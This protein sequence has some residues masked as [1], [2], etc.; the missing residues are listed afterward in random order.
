[1]GN[2]KRFKCSY[3]EVTV[4]GDVLQILVDTNTG[5][6]YLAHCFKNGDIISSSLTVLI[7]EDGKPVITK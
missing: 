5:V 6:N 3:S 1:M 2:G 4:T 7:N